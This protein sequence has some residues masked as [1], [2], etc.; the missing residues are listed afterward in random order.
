M[1]FLQVACQ[2][3]GEADNWLQELLTPR[4]DQASK[5]ASATWHTE[6]LVKDLLTV[7]RRGKADLADDLPRTNKSTWDESASWAVTN[8]NSSL[9]ALHSLSQEETEGQQ[10]DNN[11]EVAQQQGDSLSGRLPE[12]IT[13]YGKCIEAHQ[14]LVPLERLPP[15]YALYGALTGATFSE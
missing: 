11:A 7:V 5:T 4:H 15:C 13:L 2:L 6:D 12:L 1:G 10:R 3:R 8:R 9:A 14:Y